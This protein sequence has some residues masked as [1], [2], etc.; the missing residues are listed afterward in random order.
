MS[1][2]A[3]EKRDAK[4]IIPTPQREPLP[5]S[6]AILIFRVPA[7]SVPSEGF[8]PAKHIGY[9]P[10]GDYVQHRQLGDRGDSICLVPLGYPA[11]EYT[12]PHYWVDERYAIR[13]AVPFIPQDHEPPQEGKCYLGLNFEPS[14]WEAVQD[15]LLT[16]ATKSMGGTTEGDLV[17]I[18]AFYNA[19]H[20]SEAVIATVP[21]YPDLD[22]A[23]QDVA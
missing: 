9:L 21:A 13:F 1:T 8:T 12:S 11:T 10:A 15:A 7:D 4:S 19:A 6:P 14:D 20:T 16:A 22:P 3:Q 23:V 18:C 5:A 2:V 17:H